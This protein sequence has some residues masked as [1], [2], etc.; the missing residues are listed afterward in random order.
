MKLLFY[1]PRIKCLQLRNPAKNPDY[2]IEEYAHAE[3]DLSSSLTGFSWKVSVTSLE[4]AQDGLM[5]KLL[6]RV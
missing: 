2:K 4:E 3:L 6:H 5:L 1:A